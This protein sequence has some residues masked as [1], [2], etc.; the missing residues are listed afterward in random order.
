MTGR[1][2]SEGSNGRR[3]RT[4]VYCVVPPDLAAK[5]HDP[6]R[7]HFQD[8]RDVEVVVEQR[9]RDRRSGVERRAREDRPA[10]E[11]SPDQE[12]RRIHNAEGRR[13]GD[14]RAPLVAIDAPALPRRARRYADRLTF[15]ERVAPSDEHL[16]DLDTARLVTRIQSGD[17]SGF[18]DL[19]LRYFDRV[20]GYLRVTVGNGHAAEDAAQ[21]VFTQVLESLPAYERRRQPFRAWLFTIARNHAVSVVRKEGRLDVVDPVELGERR[22]SA[23]AS[24]PEL[25]VLDWISDPDLLLFIERMPAEQRQ[26]LTLRYML[27]LSM[28]EIGRAMGKSDEAVRRAHSRA[29]AFLRQRLTAVGRGPERRRGGRVGSL[30]YRGQARVVRARRFQLVSTGPVR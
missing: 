10:T 6:L 20:Y 25:P 2:G 22:E 24:E 1:V 16:E 18:A 7:A 27:G 15:V 11:R 19:Y 26:V 3:R 8:R 28:P 14:R 9:G 12:R 23:G 29:V 21:H 17:K 5:L 4:V 30:V 13:V